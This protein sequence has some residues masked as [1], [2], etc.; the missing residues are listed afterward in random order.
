MVGRNIPAKRNKVD[1][2]AD[3]LSLEALEI[4]RAVFAGQTFADQN[5]ALL[6]EAVVESN[7]IEDVFD[8][9]SVEDSVGAFAFLARHKELTTDIINRTHRMVMRSQPIL[10]ED[11]GR[12]RR[13]YV[14]VGGRLCPNPASVPY[15]MINWLEDIKNSIQADDFLQ[16][17]IEFEWIHP[18]VDGNGRMGRLLLNW[19]RFRH[20]FPPLVFKR[21]ERNEYYKLFK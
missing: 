6:L 14:Q 15:R 17:H 9:L 1:W 20:G 10:V 3:T 2:N 11:K 18:Y 5:A 12:F 7:G 13:V 19:Q 4:A 8:P 21:E 16:D